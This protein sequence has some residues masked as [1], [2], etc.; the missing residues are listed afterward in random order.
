MSEP[1]QTIRPSTILPAKR[2]LFNFH[3]E[4]GLKL[5]GA[6]AT[7]INGANSHL[8]CL[9]PLPTHGGNMDSHIYRKAANRLPALAG[10]EVIRINTRGTKSSEGASEGE[11]DNGTAEGLDVQAAIDYCFNEL[12]VSS[13]WV[14]GWSFGTDLA[15]RHA[16]D[17]RLAGL[18][19]LSPPL[20]T[21][22]DEDLRYWAQ[23]GRRVIGLIPEH[24][25]YL[26]PAA[27]AQRFSLIPQ[28][29]Q[30]SV[31]EAKHL[32]LGEPSVYRVLNEITK[33]LNSAAYPLPTDLPESAF[34]ATD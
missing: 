32:W 12:Q 4:D 28:F 20:R 18:I 8:L 9:H 1:L 6:V 17:S 23:D 3:T 34:S 27:A 2:H 31:D 33:V 25:D 26:Q 14:V 22:T 5:I 21:S 16:R 13:L 10:I 11:F 29:E 24:D 15:L 30:I 19:L 7:P